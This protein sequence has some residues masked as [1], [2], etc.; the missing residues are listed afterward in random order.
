MKESSEFIEVQAP[1]PVGARYEYQE[2]T[3]TIWSGN[4]LVAWLVELWDYRDLFY[5]LVWRDIKVRYK[6]TL[7]GAMWAVIQPF[8]SMILLSFFFGTLAGIATEGGPYPIFSYSALV[9]WT[10]FSTALSSSS[11]SMVSHSNLFTKIYFPRIAVPVTPVL[12]GLIDFAIA[13][14]LLFVLMPY[15]GVPVT[16]ALILWPI[17]VLPLLFLTSGLG[18]IMASLSVRYRDVKYALPFLIQMMMFAT[19]IIYPLAVVPASYRWLAICNP[20]TGIIEAF[21]AAVL[22]PKSFD[23]VSLGVSLVE[24]LLIL[25]FG[26]FYF[27]KTERVI[28]DVI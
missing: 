28:A 17:L 20:L 12:A 25:V 27:R 4:C 6:Q 1:L 19:P 14:L 16:S 23:F 21:R 22:H 15:Y 10:Y 5:F 11:N 18:L 26:L 2:I 9:P 7:L 3:K 13:S 8:L 24:T